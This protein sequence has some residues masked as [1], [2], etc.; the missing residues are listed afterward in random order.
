MPKP[1][2]SLIAATNRAVQA[3]TQTPLLDEYLRQLYLGSFISN[4]AKFAL[5]AAHT[6]QGYADFLLALAECELAQRE[7]RR[8]TLRRN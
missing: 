5:E 4:H 3:A 2:S 8:H 6:H 1:R 7:Q